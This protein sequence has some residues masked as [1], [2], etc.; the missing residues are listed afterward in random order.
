[1]KPID[2]RSDTVTRPTPAMRLLGLRDDGTTA[3]EMRT[4]RERLLAAGVARLDALRESADSATS[5]AA[6]DET[7]A[8]FARFRRS[9]GESAPVASAI[10]ASRARLQEE[11]RARLAAT[12][13]DLVLVALPWGEVESITDVQRK[14]AVILPADHVTP[15]RIR[16]PAGV[17][18]IQFK[19]P[20]GARVS[21]QATVKAKSE[22]VSS[23]AFAALDA[24]EYLRRAGL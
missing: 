12:A 14:T 5:L 22:T 4:A 10:G 19:H 16:V 3:Q 6:L 7:D 15:L 8:L 1:M 20:S 17:Y 18:R 9:L 2:L 13:G 21:A 24:K 11:E 23:T